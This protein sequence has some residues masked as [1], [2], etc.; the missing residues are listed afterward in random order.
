MNKVEQSIEIIKRAEKL[1][2][3]LNPKNG[4]FVGFSGGKDSAV[5]LHLIKSA[6]VHYHAYYSVT[7]ID[8]PEN[9]YYIRKYFPE[10][11]FI[12]PKQTFLKLVEQKGLPIRTKRFCCA[13]LKEP[14]GAGNVVLTG[15]R[16][17]E[18]RTRNTYR[19]VDIRSNRVEHA[20]K[21]KIHTIESIMQNE[22]RC[23]KGKDKIMLY[24]LLYWSS[25]D[26]WNYIHDNNIPINPCYE[27]TNRVGCMFCPFA[28]PAEIRRNLE[29]YPKW[30]SN[31]LTALNKYL[32]KHPQSDFYNAEDML[33]WWLSNI[34][35][36]DYQSLRNQ[37][38]MNFD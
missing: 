36:H 26:I 5:L 37:Y 24:P 15:V 7:T 33:N 27:T 23:I 38:N 17:D 34:S 16:K 28:R 31:L 19:Q 21:S 8:P 22:H 1:A 20:D 25:A 12:H 6:G 29:K 35:I 10:V 4:F 2:L 13:I 14:A 18:S 9:V 30:K 3:A 11:I 32:E